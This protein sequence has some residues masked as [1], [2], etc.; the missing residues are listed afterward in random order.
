MAAN[1]SPGTARSM[2]KTIVV[3]AQMTTNAEKIRWTI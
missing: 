3:T 2:K 1:G